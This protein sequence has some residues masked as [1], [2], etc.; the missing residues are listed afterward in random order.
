MFVAKRKIKQNMTLKSTPIG[1]SD[2]TESKNDELT[3]HNAC[4]NG[5]CFFS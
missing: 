3:F 1:C 5:N 2:K 4:E